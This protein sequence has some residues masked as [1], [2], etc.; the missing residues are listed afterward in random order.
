[1]IYHLWTALTHKPG[2]KLKNP[3]ELFSYLAL[4]IINNCIFIAKLIFYAIQIKHDWLDK[5][6]PYDTPS[7]IDTLNLAVFILTF[8]C[9][10]G[11]LII[12]GMM[13][14]IV[15]P[16]RE[17]IFEEIFHDIGANVNSV[18]HYKS[19]TAY[20]GSSKVDLITH[21]LYLNTLAFLCYDF[22]LQNNLDDL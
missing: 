20:Y 2:H 6:F 21:M 4:S 13:S 9:L 12:L 18:E 11:S 3:N 17:H 22:T 5:T 16:L 14:V 7:N 19:K 1:M 10:A 15:W 8:A